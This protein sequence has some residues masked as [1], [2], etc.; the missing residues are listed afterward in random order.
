[1]IDKLPF[2]LGFVALVSVAVYFLWF[3]YKYETSSKG[4]YGVS[5]L[6]RWMPYF[7]FML[8]MLVN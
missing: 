4:L 5:T 7:G 6:Y 8:G 2:V 1:M 3:P